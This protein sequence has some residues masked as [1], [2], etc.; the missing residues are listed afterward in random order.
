MPLVCIATLWLCSVVLNGPC[1]VAKKG[2]MKMVMKEEEEKEKQA[3][4]S[5][6]F[7][8]WYS[9]DAKRKE[10]TKTVRN[11]KRRRGWEVRREDVS[12]SKRLDVWRNES[13]HEFK[14]LIMSPG[15]IW[16]CGMKLSMCVCSSHPCECF[17]NQ[18]TIHKQ[19]CLQ[20][21]QVP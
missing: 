21:T 3:I 5:T 18:M 2:T 9:N 14:C 20:W 1:L 13:N 19:G 7:W 6:S 17:K 11:N 10:M 16:N 12:E 15:D 4:V 8:Q